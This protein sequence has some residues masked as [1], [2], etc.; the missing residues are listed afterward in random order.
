M[1]T[2]SVSMMTLLLTIAEFCTDL[3]DKEWLYCMH[4]QE[5]TYLPDDILRVKTSS[6]RR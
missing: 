4:E 2:G 6:L 5:Y 1:R 3:N